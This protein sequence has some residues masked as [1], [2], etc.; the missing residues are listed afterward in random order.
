[1]GEAPARLLPPG[2]RWAP[3]LPETLPVN[4]EL[5]RAGTPPRQTPL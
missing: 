2:R 1:M 5:E 4:A 3:E